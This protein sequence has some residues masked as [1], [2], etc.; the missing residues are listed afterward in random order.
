MTTIAW[1]GKTLAADK[2]ASDNGVMRTTTKVFKIRDHLVGFSGLLD[3]CVQM[4]EWFTNGCNP[5]D[6]PARQRTADDFVKMVVIAPTGGIYVYER[7]PVP[8]LVEDK[9]FSTGSGRDFAAAALHLG[10]SAPEAVKI[11]SELDQFTGNGVDTVSFD[12]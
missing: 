12:D 9:T 3:L 1:D 2:M 8:F 11:T 4:R 5:A 7:E 6:F 10:F